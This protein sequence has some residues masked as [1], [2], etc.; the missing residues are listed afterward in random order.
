MA[1]FKLEDGSEVEAF[2]Q[3]ELQKKIDE[4]VAGLK[5][6]RDELLG[7]H[8]KDKERLEE[9]EKAQQQAEE[10][11]QKEKGQFKEL[12][13]KTQSELENERDQA[14]RFR[15]AIQE[16]ELE[17]SAMSLVS[18]LT[19]DTKRAELLRKEA[20][21]FAKYTD[22]GVKFEVGGVEVDAVKL[23]EKLAADY[24]FLIDGSGASGGGAQGAPRSGQAGKK[25]SDMSE[26]ERKAMY[27]DD[28]D[29]FRQL[30]QS[31]KGN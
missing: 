24:P 10:D 17:S 7:L 21:Q 14:R 31:E 4:E 18:E 12:Y 27:A 6:K 13:E 9:L 2:T 19:R 20:L 23:K 30:V 25:L 29:A 15:Q 22:E 5:A 28:P 8:S 11:R 26:A 3:D 16:K 1:K